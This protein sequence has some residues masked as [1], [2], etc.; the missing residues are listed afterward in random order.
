M[1]GATE[2]FVSKL[3]RLFFACLKDAATEFGFVFTE[4]ERKS[5]PC[6]TV[7]RH[8]VTPAQRSWTGRARRLTASWPSS[9]SRR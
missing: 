2:L 4:P 1:E 3:S 6:A 8:G 9:G 7:A 5:G